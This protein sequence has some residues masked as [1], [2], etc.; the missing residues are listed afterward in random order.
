[1]FHSIKYFVEGLISDAGDKGGKEIIDLIEA[2]ALDYMQKNT[3]IL[4]VMNMRGAGVA[5]DEAL[6]SQASIR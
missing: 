5:F 2:L 6:D 4:V 3:I 1:M